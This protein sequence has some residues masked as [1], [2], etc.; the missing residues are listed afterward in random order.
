MW[1]VLSVELDWIHLWSTQ[2]CLNHNRHSIWATML[3]SLYNRLQRA[4]EQKP[5]GL[6]TP[7]LT[8]GGFVPHFQMF[9]PI[10]RQIFMCLRS[11]QKRE[12]ITGHRN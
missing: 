11:S 10:K 8:G 7:Y 2:S 1:M 12:A 5:I 3:E 6:M 4:S 9:G